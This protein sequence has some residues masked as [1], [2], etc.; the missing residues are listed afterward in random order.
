VFASASE[1]SCYLPRPSE[2]DTT[3]IIDA[4][5]GAQKNCYVPLLAE[6]D[7][8]HLHFM[9]YLPDAVLSLNRYK[10]YEPETRG[11]FFPPQR[12]DL[13]LMPLFG[14]DRA[15]HRLGSGGGYYDR[16]FAFKKSAAK[17]LLIG[18]AYAR[19]ELDQ[20]PHDTWDVPLDGILTETAFDLF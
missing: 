2:F 5:W 17:P 18:V 13:V 10:I 9:R 6:G 4:V 14:F 12:L 20:L 11:E 16:T 19:Q 7:E 3:A 15:G 1:I 8:K